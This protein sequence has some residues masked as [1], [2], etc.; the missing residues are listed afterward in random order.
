M[1]DDQITRVEAEGA[2]H[3][4]A[5]AR[6]AMAVLSAGRDGSLVREQSTA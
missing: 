5:D 2:R 3:V 4:V 1:D 6:D